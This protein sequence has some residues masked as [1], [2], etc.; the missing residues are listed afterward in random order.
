MCPACLNKKFL[1]FIFYGLMHNQEGVDAEVNDPPK[2][3]IIMKCLLKVFLPMRQLSVIY[4][5]QE[6]EL[7]VSAV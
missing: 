6:C 7:T 5:G 4:F 1:S 2:T 3:K